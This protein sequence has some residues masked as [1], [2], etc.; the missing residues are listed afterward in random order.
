MRL[1]S[2]SAHETQSF[3]LNYAPKN[4]TLPLQTETKYCTIAVQEGGCAA[5]HA[6]LYEGSFHCE[7]K[8][9]TNT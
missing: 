2:E 8:S 5:L 3:L 9:I 1:S 6:S 7:Q 4:A